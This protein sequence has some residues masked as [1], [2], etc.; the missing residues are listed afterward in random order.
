MRQL[1]HCLFF[2]KDRTHYSL[3][4]IPAL[5]LMRQIRRCDTLRDVSA[6]CLTRKVLDSSPAQ[7]GVKFVLFSYTLAWLD[8]EG[9]YRQYL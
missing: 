6:G 4:Q 5:A 3:Y 2:C 9:A 7:F 8:G 1:M